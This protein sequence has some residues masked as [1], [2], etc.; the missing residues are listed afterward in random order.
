[1]SRAIV[2]SDD[3]THEIGTLSSALRVF[4]DRYI[5]WLLSRLYWIL[6][7]AVLY[8]QGSKASDCY[9]ADRTEERSPLDS[10]S[11]VWCRPHYWPD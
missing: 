6:Y 4:V 11:R 8:S 3:N 9:I 10:R 1:M 2:E 7:W 5:I